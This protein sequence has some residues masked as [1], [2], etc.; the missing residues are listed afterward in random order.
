V[1]GLDDR[2][3]TINLVGPSVIRSDN[4]RPISAG[5]H[6][7]GTWQLGDTITARM[8]TGTKTIHLTDVHG[9]AASNPRDV[10][11]ETGILRILTAQPI[12]QHVVIGSD[13]ASHRESMSQVRI[14][15]DGFDCLHVTEITSSDPAFSVAKINNVP[16]SYPVTLC[17]GGF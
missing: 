14:R 5:P 11:I 17:P 8:D 1:Y 4:H 16:A 9:G 10:D 3:G 7:G 12:F 13:I 15:N 2:Q 6:P